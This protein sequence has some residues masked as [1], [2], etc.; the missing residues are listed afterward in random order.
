MYVE[1][2]TITRPDTTA[3]FW[4]ISTHEPDGWQQLIDEGIRQGKIIEFNDTQIDPLTYVR[5]FKYPTSEDHDEVQ[6]AFIDLLYNSLY[7]R[8]L[9]EAS[10]NHTRTTVFTT[11]P[12]VEIFERKII[13]KPGGGPFDPFPPPP[14]TPP[15]TPVTPAVPPTTPA[16]KTAK[17]K[18]VD[19]SK[20]T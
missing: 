16:A 6:A 18:A 5:I 9:Y 7:A 20:T 12:D 19:K 14:A 13:L 8:N 17:T 15:V 3:E 4:N 1:T 11:E 2:I 10:S